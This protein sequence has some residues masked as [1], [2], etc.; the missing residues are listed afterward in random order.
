MRPYSIKT[1]TYVLGIYELAVLSSASLKLSSHMN[2]LFLPKKLEEKNPTDGY[3]KKIDNLKTSAR[4]L[5]P[6]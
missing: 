3:L 1:A 2:G 4:L 6:Q 5:L